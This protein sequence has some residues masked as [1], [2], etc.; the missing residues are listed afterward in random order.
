M[1]ENKIGAVYLESGSSLFY[2]TG[3]RWGNSERMLEYA[4]AS[5]L[6]GFTP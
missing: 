2:Y 5:G 1:V 4:S 3:M 6:F